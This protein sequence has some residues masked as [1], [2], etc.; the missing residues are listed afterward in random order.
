MPKTY[1]R[2]EKGHGKSYIGVT[3]LLAIT[4]GVIVYWLANKITSLA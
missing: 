4:L 3:P 2:D 1:L